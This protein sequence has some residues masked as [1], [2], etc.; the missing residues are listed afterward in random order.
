MREDS[1]FI[2]VVTTGGTIDKIY[3][4]ALSSYQVGESFVEKLLEAANVACPYRVIELMRKDSLELEDQDR[5]RLRAAI[6]ALQTRRIVVT[7]GTDTMTLSAAALAPLSDRTIVLTGALSPA[8][9]TQSD[10]AFNLGMAFAAAQML[11][12]GVYIAMNGQVFAGDRVRKDRALG[13]FVALDPAP[14]LDVGAGGAE[15]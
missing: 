10:A 15:P 7:H 6:E 8:R 13:R 2:A 4:D 3:F 12:A 5:V 1:G 11:P 14:R 9:F